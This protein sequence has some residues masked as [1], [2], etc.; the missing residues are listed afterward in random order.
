MQSIPEHSTDMGAQSQRLA[1]GYNPHQKA[2]TLQPGQ[3]THRKS[4]GAIGESYASILNKNK[5]NTWPHKPRVRNSLPAETIS[6]QL[7]SMFD[8]LQIESDYAKYIQSVQQMQQGQYGDGSQG[9]QS[10]LFPEAS[11]WNAGGQQMGHPG[12]W[13][14]HTNS[15]NGFVLLLINKRFI[16]I[17]L[18]NSNL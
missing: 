12:G 16:C 17:S 9:N 2:A 3:R 14:P 10:Q 1:P 8:G 4:E 13:P 5:T 6:M 11:L 7:H 18:T 15:I